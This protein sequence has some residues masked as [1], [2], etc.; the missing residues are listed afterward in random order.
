MKRAAPTGQV[1]R[2]F[3]AAEMELQRN[4]RHK[5]A[6]IWE[7][8][9]TPAGEKAFLKVEFNWCTSSKDFGKI[10]QKKKFLGVTA[11]KIFF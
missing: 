8:I 4:L 5:C 10:T 3:P 6:G 9:L 2:M 7:T 1:N 11:P